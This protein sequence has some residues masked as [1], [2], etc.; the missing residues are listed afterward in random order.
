MLHFSLLE[1]SKGVENEVDVPVQ[2]I[3]S[4]VGVQKGGVFVVLQRSSSLLRHF[5]NCSH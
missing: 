2:F 5:L 4:H 3:G 1:L